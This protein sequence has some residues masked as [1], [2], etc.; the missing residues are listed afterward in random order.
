MNLFRLL[1][2]GVLLLGM[3]L[4]LTACGQKG[5]LILPPKNTPP[6]VVN[7]VIF[8]EKD[9]VDDGQQALDGALVP[10]SVEVPQDGQV[11]ADDTAPG[12]KTVEDGKDSDEIPLGILPSTTKHQPLNAR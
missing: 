11:P 7:P 3:L 8:P 4:G 6:K 1:G 5:P 9:A 2:K 10:E 12:S